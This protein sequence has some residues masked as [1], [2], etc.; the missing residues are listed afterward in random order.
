MRLPDRQDDNGAT[1][2]TELIEFEIVGVM[3]GK[4]PARVQLLNISNNY[5]DCPGMTTPENGKLAFIMA[6]RLPETG[7]PQATMF[8]VDSNAFS[9]LIAFSNAGMKAKPPKPAQ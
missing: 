3:S 5:D 6:R 4:L 7:E 2:R 8:A 1:L 9:L